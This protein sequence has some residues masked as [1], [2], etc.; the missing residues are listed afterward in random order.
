MGIPFMLEANSTPS[1]SIPFWQKKK[2][3]KK[4]KGKLSKL[5]PEPLVMFKTLS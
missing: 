3:K 2:K 1:L 4:R 5:V